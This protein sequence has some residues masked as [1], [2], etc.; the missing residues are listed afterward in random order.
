MDLEL[1]EKGSSEV[2]LVCVIFDK[3]TIHIDSF[4]VLHGTDLFPAV[5][6]LI[7]IMQFGHNFLMDAFLLCLARL[8]RNY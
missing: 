3:W 4:E 2:P 7:V 8:G 6:L 1:L 5:Y